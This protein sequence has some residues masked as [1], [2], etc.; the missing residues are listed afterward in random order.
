ML[1]RYIHRYKEHFQHDQC[2]LYTEWMVRIAHDGL[3]FTSIARTDHQR[4]PSQSQHLPSS[5]INVREGA[6]ANE[7]MSE[8]KQERGHKE[9]GGVP[10][11]S[12]RGLRV[13]WGTAKMGGG[14]GG[15]GGAGGGKGGGGGGGGA[16]GGKGEGRAGGGRGERR[17]EGD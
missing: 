2:S 14:G 15:G 7:G 8:K 12:G 10:Q 1:P 16:G 11:R 13:Q 6:V 17:G 3:F 9:G 5:N 4:W